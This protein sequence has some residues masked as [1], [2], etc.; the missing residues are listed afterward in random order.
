MTIAFK[1]A[2]E[3]LEQVFT[4]VRVWM[5]RNRLRKATIQVRWSQPHHARDTHR[6][7]VT[8]ED[9]EMKEEELEA[10]AQAEK[11]YPDLP[12][13]VDYSAL[14]EAA[15]NVNAFTYDKVIVN[16]IYHM[17]PNTLQVEVRVTRSPLQVN[18]EKMF[19]KLKDVIRVGDLYFRCGGVDIMDLVDSK[20][21]RYMIVSQFYPM[22]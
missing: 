4:Q 2:G 15:E 1:L 8:A 17:E 13:Q 20:S 6:W 9:D 22:K 12:L 10:R 5:D 18:M 21:N 7:V 14:V 19:I 3:N 11:D 16:G